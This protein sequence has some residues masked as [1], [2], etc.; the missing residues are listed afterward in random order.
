MKIDLQSPITRHLINRIFSIAAG[1]LTVVVIGSLNPA[2][3]QVRTGSL[4]LVPKGAVAAARIDWSVAGHDDRFRRMLNA[5]Q[6]DRG[7]SQLRISGSE[8]SEIVVFSGMNSTLTG[9]IAGI[10]RGTF[11]PQAVI[12]QLKSQGLV[13][14][15]YRGRTLYFNPVDRSYTSILRSGVLVVGSEKGVQGVL[16]VET[17]PRSGLMLRP[18]FSTVLSN[19]KN[20]RHPISFM[21]GIPNEY[22]SVANI[23]TKVVSA[24]FSIA[25]LGPVGFV[26]NRIGFPYTLG[27][28]IARHGSNFPVV[29]LA[30]M[31]DSTSA[32][33]ISG[34]LNVMQG[35]NL[36]MLSNQMSS[37]D[38]EMLRNVS[39]SRS[40]ALLSIR[41]V[42]RE[43]DLPH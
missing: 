14:S 39:V 35:I 27:F 15:A 17:N 43:Q 21:M 24:M 4:G 6:L 20:S 30:Q 3:S 23:A 36:G 26:L 16:D 32:A 8:I 19:L 38:R 33:L 41:M 1:C 34:T 25:G 13:E 37:T 42:L 29:L 31:K 11:K 9:T 7:L 2:L 22:R 12:A 10:F 40:G 28:S 18:P 5:E